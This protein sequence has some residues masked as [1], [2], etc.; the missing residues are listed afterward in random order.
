MKIVL[1]LIFFILLTSF[2]VP[3]L[4]DDSIYAIS[5]NTVIK[6]NVFKI[7]LT[8]PVLSDILIDNSSIYFYTYH[9]IYGFNSTTGNKTFKTSIE[10]ITNQ[11]QT[12]NYI[13]ATTDHTIYTINKTS[14]VIEQEKVYIKTIS[15][16]YTYIMSV[17]SGIISTY[18][19]IAGNNITITQIGND[20]TISA[21]VSGIKG[22]K[23]DQ[24]LP[25]S[26]GS[27]GSPG[28]P[29]LNGTN[30]G[31]NR[32]VREY[33]LGDGIT[34]NYSTNFSIISGTSE[35][36]L[37]G[38]KQNYNRIYTEGSNSINFT[39]VTIPEDWIEIKYETTN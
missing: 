6:Q 35:I 39:E 14:G 32:S 13:I 7:V 16:I 36:Y 34:F 38:A 5:G 28:A 4:A 19:F 27:N 33:H 9:Y 31:V 15:S 8:E 37:N 30:G 25:G 23:G 11:E 26:N 12:D 24:G 29:G 1:Q 18:N 3:T 17:G 2:I 20:V 21:N 10:K 22:D